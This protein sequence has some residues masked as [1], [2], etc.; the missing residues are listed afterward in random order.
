MRTEP[1][2]DAEIFAL[3]AS[4]AQERLWFLDRFDPG[5]A[6]YNVPWISTV[7]G[8]LDRNAF[9]R[10]VNRLVARHEALRTCFVE[11]GGQPRQIIRPAVTVEVGF[12][13]LGNLDRA[14][15][16]ARLQEICS[17]VTS[18]PFDLGQAPLFRLELVASPGETTIIATIHH[19]VA[20]GWSIGIFQN[21]LTALYQE[22]LGRGSAALPEL[23]LQYADFA[24]WQRRELD[25]QRLDGL[26]AFWR[27]CLQDATTLLELPTDHPRP[28]RQTFVGD[29][30][31]FDLDDELARATRALA[32]QRDSTLF[33]TL[34]SAFVVLLYRL[35]RQDDLLVGTPIAG[36]KDSDVAH[37]IGLFV[38]TLVLRATVR[39]E[40]SF[41]ELL[42]DVRAMTLEVFEHQDM[43]FEKLV[44]DLNPKRDLSHSPLIQVL[45]S[46]QNIP[47]L[48]QARSGGAGRG[49]S[50][51][52]QLNAHTATAK[53]D[54]ALFVSEAADGLGC[55]IEFNTDLFGKATIERFAGYYV[56]LLSGIVEDPARPI[57]GY[58]LMA[59]DE[60]QR[61]LRTA[62]GPDA[63][64]P[65][66]G[67]HELFEAQCDRSPDAPAIV[68]GSAT[69]TYAELNG[70]ANRIARFLLARGVRAGDRVGILLPR[71]VDQIA[72]TLA[73]VKAGA[74]YLPLDPGSPPERLRAILADAGVAVVVSDQDVPQPALSLDRQAR[75]IGEQSPA[76]LGVAFSAEQPLYVLYTSGSTGR[77]KGVVMP[78]RPIVNLIEWHQRALGVP[79]GTTTAQFAPLHFDVASQEIFATLT[80]G[81][82]L[83][84]VDEESRRDGRRLLRLLAELRVGRLFAPPVALEQLAGAAVAESEALPRLRHVIVAGDRLRVTDGVRAFFEQ[85]P[86]ARLVNQYGPTETHVVSSHILQGRAKD[87]PLHPPIGTPIANCR[88]YVL[89]DELRPVPPSVTGELYIGGVPVSLGYLGLS[90]ET[91]ARFLADPF[92]NGERVYRSGDL[93]R[94]DDDGVLHFLERADQQ[95]KL[96][97]FRIEP[98]EVEVTLER[99]PGVAAAVV[100][101]RRTGSGDGEL[102]GYVLAADGALLDRTD[103]RAFLAERLPSYM[104]PA[105]LVQVEAFPMT[106]SGKVDRLRLPD[107]ADGEAVARRDAQVA[108]RTPVEAF[109]ARVWSDL[110]KLDDISLHDDFFEL[111][112]HSLTA[113]QLVSRIRDEFGV[114]LAIRRIFERSRLDLLALEVL[115]CRLDSEAEANID[116]LL[117]EVESLSDEDLDGLL[118][119]DG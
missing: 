81:G 71:G 24:V 48:E 87:W 20:D 8:P 43:P 31:T 35:T 113:T 88:L 77:P 11:E 28:V 116:L 59:E 66:A 75:E 53:F 42:A 76:N 46:L 80:S 15:S 79:E 106:S 98:G 119:G 102:V 100:V 60:R 44:H 3:P 82:C 58:P 70:Y 18:A 49:A 64:Y 118:P 86:N 94:Y 111:G 85:N 68:D 63:E 40:M 34:L 37:V 30:H 97:G 17:E 112:G 14:A 7:P 61:C 52:Q 21:E 67:C 54:F 89:D 5:T 65:Q 93:C 25:G 38:N 32:G 103:L 26:R 96:R 110:L 115:Q 99:H 69:L 95:I 51:S 9:N 6:L 107:P 108:P 45:F 36:R 2:V 41:D 92:R 83:A 56:T 33:M 91:R 84:V 39:P 57:G 50:L 109:L 29:V 74:A 10:A 47:T 23:R 101:K 19:I 12:Q 13:E 4:Y 90:E 16:Q 62:A 73:V 27:Q 104:V 105:R 78:H 114:E 1:S 55:A 22:E 72:T 117:S